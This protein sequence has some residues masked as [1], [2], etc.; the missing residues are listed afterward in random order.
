MVDGPI[1][2]D[3]SEV[4]PAAHSH[5]RSF[6]ARTLGAI[7]LDASVFEEV[8]HDPRA[9][10]QAAVVVGM[11]GLARGI[12]ALVADEVVGLVGSVVIAYLSWLFVC[13]LIWLVGVVVDRDTST[14]VELLRTLGFA[15]API[16]LLI[17][18]VIP[19]LA[20]PPAV[21]PLVFAVHAAAAV[22]LVVA[23]RAA[24]DVSTLR[25]V[26]ICGVVVAVLAALAAYVLHGI[27]IRLE[28]MVD[29][30]TSEML[31]D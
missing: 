11:A 5:R 4:E 3:V 24:L 2:P 16:L 6:L 29:L 20:Y 31:G 8:E 14:F 13:S 1:A 30:A 19:A 26:V 22:A 12:A 21:A 7:R 15:A 28:G 10:W 17:L 23:A 25:A 18:G 9:L 27:A